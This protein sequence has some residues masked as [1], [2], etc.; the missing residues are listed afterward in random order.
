MEEISMTST[1]TTTPRAPPPRSLPPA[2][3]ED[4][5]ERM[6]MEE[7][8]Y[9]AQ[10]RAQQ[11]PPKPPFRTLTLEEMDD[12]STRQQ[13]AGLDAIIAERHFE[14]TAP[15]AWDRFFKPGRYPRL[16]FAG[17]QRAG[18]VGEDRFKGR[19]HPH[20]IWDAEGD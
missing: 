17:G 8:E 13:L 9:W 6:W 7:G 14:N 1:T 20:L 10:Q 5:W 3:R 2:E 4:M 11:P 15:A 19:Y 12:I 16:H 18:R